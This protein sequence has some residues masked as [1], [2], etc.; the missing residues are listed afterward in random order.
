VPKEG[1]FEW[2]TYSNPTVGYTLRI[3]SIYVAHESKGGQAVVFRWQRRAPV[4]ITFGN[5]KKA[6]RR[7][8]WF[9]RESQGAIALGGRVGRRYL[10][11]H[12]DGPFCSRMVAFVVP[13][14]GRELT[15]EFRADGKLPAV[16]RT[17][18]S[19]FA[20]REAN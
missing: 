3:P 10:Y 4:K 20:W 18:V 12:C 9:G 17:I 8:L 16:Y 2:T 14:R 11:T 5:A 19:S 7:I 15:L 6:R 13:H 1:T